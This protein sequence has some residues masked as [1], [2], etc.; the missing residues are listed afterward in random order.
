[1][2]TRAPILLALAFAPALALASGDS[3]P[4]VNPRDLAMGGALGAAQR[5]AGAVYANP[6]ALARLEPGLTATVALPALDIGMT[7]SAPVGPADSS[8]QLELAIPGAAFVSYRGESPI[9]RFG[10]GLGFN[11]P[12]GG[13]IF[14]DTTWP[15]R[16]A[17]Q[18][19]DRRVYG[20]YLNGGLEVLPR[21]RVG[22]GAI[23][24][25]S[26]EYLTQALDF[27]QSEGSAEVSTKGGAFAYQVALE[28]Q[29]FA[30]LPLTVALNYRHKA[31]LQLKGE[32]AFHAVPDALRPQLP[33]QDVTHGYTV[34]NS[35]DA[36][37]ALQ[38]TKDLLVAF[39][40]T[41][42]RF[43]VYEE[44]RFV[45][46]AGTTVLVPRDYGDGHVF[47]LGA[48]YRIAPRWELRA[49]LLRDVSGM[50]TERFSPS[51][52]DSSS[53]CVSAGAGW[54]IAPSLSADAGLFVALFDQ[55]KGTGGFPGTYDIHAE[56]LSVGLTWRPLAR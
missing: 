20:V 10:A 28:A 38:A 4:N 23:Y 47:R 22:G 52:P 50:K 16:F 18:T 13:N 29:P 51:L 56:I 42:D 43:S 36:A 25:Y 34:P 45:G 8:S 41:L 54:R 1:M 5:D 19:V 37:V 7:W 12:Y 6:A 31:T 49:G 30:E 26:T 17:V 9:G 39:Q 21:L 33:D 14:W 46:S 15:G 55:V 53:W 3:D 48:E 35:F 24:Y 27:L 2:R 32:A 44:D 40:Y 11:V